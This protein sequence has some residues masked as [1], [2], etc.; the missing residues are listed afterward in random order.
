MVANILF[1]YY[2]LILGHASSFEYDQDAKEFLQE[3]PNG[4]VLQKL[5][6][7]PSL[8]YNI[9]LVNGIIPY[10]SDLRMFFADDI[11]NCKELFTKFIQ[12]QNNVV[13][14]ADVY[15]FVTND[16]T[17]MEFASFTNKNIFLMKLN[18]R[19]SIFTGFIFPYEPANLIRIYVIL[20]Q[21]S[22]REH[23]N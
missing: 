17:C 2:I 11:Q 21:H 5:L 23:F 16:S 9:S 22:C 1:S 20:K 8:E 4:P 12:S 10:F 19:G 13:S 18:E 6:C 7:Y 15:N 3:C 14:N